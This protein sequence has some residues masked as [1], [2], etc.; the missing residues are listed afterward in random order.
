[1]SACTSLRGKE[2]NVQKL[3]A[4][5]ASDPRVRA[6]S[7]LPP[8][9]S[10]SRRWQT[11]RAPGRPHDAT[12]TVI[13]GVMALR[14]CSASRRR[15]V[16]VSS[17][18]RWHL[19]IG[20]SIVCTSECSDCQVFTVQHIRGLKHE[21]NE[22]L[23]VSHPGLSM[24]GPEEAPLLPPGTAQKGPGQGQKQRG[25]KDDASYRT[26]HGHDANARHATVDVHPGEQNGEL[27]KSRSTIHVR[28]AIFMALWY[29]SR[30]LTGKL[31]AR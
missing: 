30:S 3:A 6:V 19:N 4:P 10:S 28:V 29:A 13:F 12:R 9:G 21:R 11:C 15:C 23:S 5:N 2:L 17:S 7:M 18:R 22:R 1:M 16:N 26:A 14:Y 25:F 8:V 20:M 31:I 27:E 24:R